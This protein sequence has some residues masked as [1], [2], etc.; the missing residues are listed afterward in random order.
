[1][2]NYE[3]AYRD[4]IGMKTVL[5]IEGTSERQAIINLQTELIDNGNY[6][7]QLIDIQEVEDDDCESQVWSIKDGPILDQDSQDALNDAFNNFVNE[8]GLTMKEVIDNKHK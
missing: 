8:D 4:C 6:M 3:I 5:E 1:M 7:T 2:K